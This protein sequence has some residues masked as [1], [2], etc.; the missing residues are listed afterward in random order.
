MPKER[1]DIIRHLP[2]EAK[3]IIRRHLPKEANDIIRRH[4][5]QDLNK[6]TKEVITDETAPYPNQ[7][8]VD[9]KQYHYCLPED[10]K[11]VEEVEQVLEGIKKDVQNNQCSLLPVAIK[12]SSEAEQ[13]I[14]KINESAVDPGYGAIVGKIEG[15]KLSCIY[16]KSGEQIPQLTSCNSPQSNWTDVNRYYILGDGSSEKDFI[17]FFKA[18]NEIEKND[19]GLP[20]KHNILVSWNDSLFSIVLC[21]DS[22]RIG[23][24]DVYIPSYNEFSKTQ[25][26]PDGNVKQ[27]FAKLLAFVVEPLRCIVKGY[28]SIKGT[29]KQKGYKHIQQSK[30]N[31][32][33]EAAELM[34]KLH[35]QVFYKNQ[36]TFMELFFQKK[37][38]TNERGGLFPASIGRGALVT[39]EILFQ[40]LEQPKET[41]KNL[42]FIDAETNHKDNK[43]AQRLRVKYNIERR[44]LILLQFL[45]L[46]YGKTV[47]LSYSTLMDKLKI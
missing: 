11:F 1:N 2:K 22:D 16:K 38:V 23:H 19:I 9:E 26:F 5:M 44:M 3:D 15:N 10:D 41:I 34:R 43:K 12:L 4:S 8:K 29:K 37:L 36:E 13:H 25:S 45:I 28:N 6:H 47:P 20:K 18:I 32:R 30:A 21:I 40:L 31:R 24:E 17:S 14:K 27:D 46:K 39:S 33:V 42:K 35:E 7:E